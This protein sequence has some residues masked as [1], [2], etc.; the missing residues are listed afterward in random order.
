MASPIKPSDIKATLPATDSSACARLKKVIVDFPRRVYDWFSYIYN[1]DGTFSEEFK[2]DFCAIQ[3]DD[4]ESGEETP[5][6]DSNPGGNLETPFIKA[7]AAVRH[8]GGI[9][10]VFSKVNGATRYDIYRGTTNSI[11][12]T[13]TKRIRKSLIADFHNMNAPRSKLCLRRDG[14]I[15][16]VDVNGGPLYNPTTRKDDPNSNAVD[17]Q[18]VYYYWV[19]AKNADGSKSDYA[20]PVIGFSRSVTNYTPIG[21]SKLLYSGQEESPSGM[22]NKTRMRVVLRGGGGGGGGGGDYTLPTWNKFHI[23]SIGS[24]NSSGSETA[25]TDGQPI[26]FTLSNAGGQNHNF[27]QGEELI[28]EGQNTSGWHSPAKKY[29]V[30]EVLTQNNKYICEPLSGMDAPTASTTTNIP[31]TS[32]K[33]FGLIH[34]VSD[35]QQT[36]VCGGGGGAGGILQAVFELTDVTSVRVRTLDVNNLDNGPSTGLRNLPDSDYWH[37]YQGSQFTWISGGRGREDATTPPTAG[38]PRPGNQDGITTNT[39]PYRTQLEVRK[40][41]SGGPNNDGWHPIAWVSNGE[42]GGYADGASASGTKSTKG[43]GSKQLYWK[44]SNNTFS[45][46]AAT[47]YSLSRYGTSN[48]SGVA[49]LRNQSFGGNVGGVLFYGG[50]DGTDGVGSSSGMGAGTPGVGGNAWDS[51]E[52]KGP[53]QAR[54][55]WAGN[56][57]S[58]ANAFDFNAPGSG[59]YASYG[60]ADDKWGIYARGGKALGGCAFITYATQDYD[61]A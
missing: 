5:I 22:T 21:S 28:L 53:T 38:E 48:A 19:V 42:G 55:A 27:Q 61:V 43:E 56:W 23:T 34:S 6:T 50:A 52:P 54:A 35:E 60:E 30:K 11:T 16:Y 1:E 3:C 58:I 45:A 17:G 59:G 25:Y 31:N 41:T 4:V 36:R 10:I 2:T 37:S 33:T 39:G 49:V 14:T 13:T 44:S 40:G 18:Q 8:N 46:T 32:T 29:I 7:G 12:A 26:L 51:L 24:V 20:G 47:G 57:D 9:P 15:L